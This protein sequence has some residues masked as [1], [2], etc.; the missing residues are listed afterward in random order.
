MVNVKKYQEGSYAKQFK[1]D[2][3]KDDNG[4]LIN[5]DGTRDKTPQQRK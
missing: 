2:V 5:I 4:K 3:K 1:Q